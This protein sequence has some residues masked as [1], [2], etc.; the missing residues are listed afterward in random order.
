MIRHQWLGLDG[1]GIQT[2][3]YTFHTSITQGTQNGS[4]GFMLD[5]MFDFT[6][7]FNNMRLS[8][9][10][11]ALFSA[12]VLI[13]PD[14]PGLRYPNQISLIQGKIIESLRGIIVQKPNRDP[15]M[16]VYITEGH[17]QIHY[18]YPSVSLFS[19]QPSWPIC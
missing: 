5:S 11:K 3:T 10:E 17:A 9:D 16:Y 14:R 4:G 2:N 1:V 7:R 18:H 15:G 13:S 8:D 6:E 19:I 12:V